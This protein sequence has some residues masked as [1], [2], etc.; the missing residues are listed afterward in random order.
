MITFCGR[1]LNGEDVFDPKLRPRYGVSTQYMHGD[2]QNYRIS[3]WTGPRG[4]INMRR[5]PGR[6]LTAEVAGDVPTYALD[7][8]VQLEL[9]RWQGRIVFK[10]DGQTLADWTDDAPF[11]DGFFSLRLMAAAKGWYDDYEVYRL[12]ENPFQ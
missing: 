5:A 1:G 7:R 4:T 10:V 2:I 12:L 3:Y 9:I 8:E 11:G 6:E